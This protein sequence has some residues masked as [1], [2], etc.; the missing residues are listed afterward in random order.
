M[1]EDYASISLDLFSRDLGTPGYGNHL[2]DSYY[3]RTFSHNSFV[4]NE[5]SQPNSVIPSRIESIENGFKATIN[6]MSE[7][8][9]SPYY[10]V[11]CIRTLT[12]E[13]DSILDRMEL[14][15]PSEVTFDWLLHMDGE[16]ALPCTEE[17]A[18][19]ACEHFQEMKKQ[20]CADFTASFR[21]ENRILT[22]GIPQ[23]P[24][25]TIFSG[26]APG[27]PADCLLTQIIQRKTG[28]SAVFHARYCM[29]K[30]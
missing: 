25:T 6:S 12:V 2:T 29:K 13:G 26:K 17:S 15:A 10:H 21:M 19:F 5:T 1:H 9:A 22:V 16:A 14:N 20:P 11:S 27:N 23:T 18:A 24:D 30:A 7:D 8:P 4:V 3:R 28:N